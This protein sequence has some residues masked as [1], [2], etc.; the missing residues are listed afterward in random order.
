MM[1]ACIC[2]KRKKKP[3]KFNNS[4]NSHS[5]TLKAKR[6]KEKV[7]GKKP[8]SEKKKEKQK[9]L[10]KK[11]IQKNKRKKFKKMNQKK[12]ENIEVISQDK[13]LP[14]QI[15]EKLSAYLPNQRTTGELFKQEYQE[16]FNP[17]KDLCFQPEDLSSWDDRS[18]TS[19]SHAL[20]EAELRIGMVNEIS[21]S[22]RG[23][24]SMFE[25]LSNKT[26]KSFCVSDSSFK[27]YEGN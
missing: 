15:S 19:I 1:L 11:S 3:K 4:I 16:S 13:K 26:T 6:E 27:K 10:G 25:K 22:H 14:S 20:R 5:P 12:L 8:I 2:R 18:N 23:K 17:E 24:N 21:L 7:L 9:L